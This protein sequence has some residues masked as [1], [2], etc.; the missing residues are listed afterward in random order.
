MIYVFCG[1]DREKIAKEIKKIL[2]ED[3]EVFEG[4]KLGVQDIV[5]ICLGTS[6]FA[7]K[8]KIL[9]RDLTPARKDEGEDEGPGVDF[10]TELIK[11]VNT[12]HEIV[13][14]ETN[15]SRKKS[16]AEFKKAKGVKFFEFKI[17]RED[18]RRLSG[19]LDLAFRDGKQA[20]MELRKLED[21]TEPYSLVGVFAFNLCEKYNYRRGEKEKRALEALS[22]VDMLMK[23]TSLSPWTYLESFLLQ[24]SSL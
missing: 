9:I 19:I 23:T 24:V 20:V 8:R 18:F 6:L 15:K 12:S 17:H 5:N 2:G 4:E 16:F 3:Y 21:E 10:Y 1:D 7:D 13:I 14:W 22:R 11:Y